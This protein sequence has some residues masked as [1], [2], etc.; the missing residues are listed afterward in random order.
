MISQTYGTLKGALE[1]MD[2][3]VDAPQTSSGS[4]CLASRRCGEEVHACR[5]SLGLVT[6]VNDSFKR[7]C[8]CRTVPAQSIMPMKAPG[9]N[10]QT[11][12][13]RIDLHLLL[14]SAFELGDRTGD[15]DGDTSA[16][17]SESE[18]TDCPPIPPRRLSCEAEPPKKKQKCTDANTPH[19]ST[20]IQTELAMRQLPST[21][22]AYTALNGDKDPEACKPY[23]ISDL[24][25]LG[26]TLQRWDGM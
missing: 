15:D 17:G 23:M 21:K 9:A 3:R 25:D 16:S 26:F 8:T 19:G 13:D 11:A 10:V 20:C 18:R 6:V 2:G 1:H 22:S 14:Q 4:R 24:L 7:K 5:L 12:L